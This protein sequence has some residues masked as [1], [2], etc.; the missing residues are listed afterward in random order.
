[1]VLEQIQKFPTQVYNA[2]IIRKTS[3]L[4]INNIWR[5]HSSA[6]C[7]RKHKW[8]ASASISLLHRSKF[9]FTRFITI[10]LDRKKKNIHSF[11]ANFAISFSKAKAYI[12]SSDSHIKDHRFSN[13][14]RIVNFFGK[15]NSGG[16]AFP[17]IK[18]SASWAKEETAK[19]KEKQTKEEKNIC[20][21]YIFYRESRRCLPWL[22]DMTS[23]PQQQRI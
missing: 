11:V 2:P 18:K 4:I 13:Y 9:H 15:T 16:R 19:K 23:L 12:D 3:P 20:P 21:K 14:K 6:Y 17:F 1:M 8:L 22:R 10:V 5:I 7:P